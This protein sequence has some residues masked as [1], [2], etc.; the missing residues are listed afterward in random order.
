MRNSEEINGKKLAS[1]RLTVARFTNHF[2]TVILNRKIVFRF[3][4][5]LLAINS[6][7]ETL[8]IRS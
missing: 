3:V 1:L 4:L 2:H 5:A 6:V 7:V 8:K